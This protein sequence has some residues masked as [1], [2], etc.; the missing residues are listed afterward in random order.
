MCRPATS[1]TPRSPSSAPGTGVDRPLVLPAARVVLAAGPAAHAPPAAAAHAAATA[2]AAAAAHA[3]ATAAA[4]AR[5][6]L[7][8][9]LRDEG[10]RGLDGLTGSP[11]RHDA[12]LGARGEL[13]LGRD[14]QGGP[15]AAVDLPDGGARPANH[16]P[17]LIVRDAHHIRLLRAAP[18][19]SLL[20]VPHA[21]LAKAAGA[22]GRHARVPAAE[23][24]PAAAARA[25]QAGVGAA[26]AGAAP[27]AAVGL[28]LRHHALVPAQRAA[29][30]AAAT[31]TCLGL[32]HQVH[33][34]LVHHGRGCTPPAN[35]GRRGAGGRSERQ[36]RRAG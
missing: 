18:A 36:R 35:A 12:V 23:H 7:M 33:R 29:A 13:V 16:C 1:L 11:Q 19:S 10:A 2:H 24:V 34:G 17:D 22:R 31:T 9:L 5:L 21:T 3:A 20:V 28:L 30:A 4:G 6:G 27:A 26:P 8:Q 25:P 32:L 15:G 14:V